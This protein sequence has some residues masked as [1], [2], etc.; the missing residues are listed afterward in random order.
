M[1]YIPVSSINHCIGEN[2]D[3]TVNRQLYC[4]KG[5]DD[6]GNPIYTCAKWRLFKVNC[7]KINSLCSN[8]SQAYVAA[9]TVCN[10]HLY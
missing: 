9:I 10:Q 7:S 4:L 6:G 2:A 8:L 1:A 5:F 3:G